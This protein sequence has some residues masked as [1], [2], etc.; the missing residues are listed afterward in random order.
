ME[1]PRSLDLF[2]VLRSVSCIQLYV[3]WDLYLQVSQDQYFPADLLLLASTNA[4]GICY[5]E[6][7]SC[8]D[9][10][11]VGVVLTVLIFLNMN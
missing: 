5:I 8:K 9:F 10:L 6:V 4:D 7:K 2:T 11:F 1:Y 3:S